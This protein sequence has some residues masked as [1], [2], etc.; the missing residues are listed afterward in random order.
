MAM[1]LQGIRPSQI[2]AVKWA[3]G[4]P[5]GPA[6][7]SFIEVP[8][9]SRAACHNAGLDHWMMYRNQGEPPDVWFAVDDDVVPCRGLFDRMER[10]LAADPSI[11][12]LGAWN[13]CAERQ[14]NGDWHGEQ[15]LVT[16]EW[17]QY[18]TDFN[19]GGAV[20]AIPRR[21]IEEV[22][23]YNEEMV[24]L[25]DHDLTTRVRQAG[26][27]AAIARTIFAVVLEDDGVDPTYRQEMVDT[28]FEMRKAKLGY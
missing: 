13:D 20:Q 3:D 28:F 8:G 5:S 16:D 22:G 27:E 1:K 24:W 14:T 19:V 15:R 10:V 18:G 7:L 12:L 26:H 11:Y 2:V 6:G 4:E 25:E 9:G 21:T 17:V 23:T